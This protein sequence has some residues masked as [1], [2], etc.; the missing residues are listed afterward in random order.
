MQLARLL[1]SILPILLTNIVATVVV[2]V[3]IWCVR[4]YRWSARRLSNVFREYRRTIRDCLAQPTS[5]PIEKVLLLIV[6]SG[7]LYVVIWV[8]P[9]AR[10]MP[11]SLTI[12]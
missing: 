8:R 6:E 10:I 1:L 2:S 5:T 4:C 9:E 12:T 11:R 7:G 3:K